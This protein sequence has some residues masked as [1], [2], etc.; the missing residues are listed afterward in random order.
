MILRNKTEYYYKQFIRIK[1]ICDELTDQGY[2]ID[3]KLNR[4]GWIMLEKYCDYLLKEF[5]R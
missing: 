4:T 3:D 1:K 5:Q 2:P